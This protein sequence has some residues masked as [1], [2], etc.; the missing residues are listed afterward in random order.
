MS[1][2]IQSQAANKQQAFDQLEQLLPS[3]A[4]TKSAALANAQA[5][6]EL[7]ADDD[8]KDVLITAQAWHIVSGDQVTDVSVL[9][10]ANLVQRAA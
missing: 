5:A 1:Y 7:L 10:T 6:V 2:P 3:D 4:P 8:T 9:A